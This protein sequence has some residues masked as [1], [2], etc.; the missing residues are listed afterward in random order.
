[1]DGVRQEP[2]TGHTVSMK[3]SKWFSIK[4]LEKLLNV[5]KERDVIHAPHSLM[6]VT[7]ALIPTTTLASSSAAR[8]SS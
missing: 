2:N 7:L 3:Y 5:Y 8:F 6:T 1:M 4:L